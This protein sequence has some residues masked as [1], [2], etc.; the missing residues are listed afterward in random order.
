MRT[1]PEPSPEI[2]HVPL[3]H[4]AS[5]LPLAIPDGASAWRVRRL[6]GGRPRLYLDGNK[7]PLQLALGYTAADVEEILPPGSYR[8]DLVDRGGAPLDLVVPI[9]IAAYRNSAANDQ[10][11]EP[12]PVAPAV[13]PAAMS[14]VRL[15]LEANVRA[16]QMAFQHNE[17]TL[18]ASLR[19]AETLRDGVR[20]LAEA[21]GDWI[22]SLTTARGFSLRNVALPPAPASREV[23]END[24]D[25]DDDDD[26]DE[27]DDE[28]DVG[29]GDTWAPLTPLI[30]MAGPLVT[31]LVSD[32]LNRRNAAPTTASKKK[33][34]LAS[35]F[36]WRKAAPDPHQDP[37]PEAP[38]LSLVELMAAMPP[39][40][41]GRLMQVRA[42]LTANEQDRLKTLFQSFDPADLPMITAEFS[43]RTV[44]ELLAFLRARIADAVEG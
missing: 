4:D 2:T 40:V 1:Q 22:K 13:L 18:A 38:K 3:A 14:D 16:M 26:D 27:D 34:D 15:V 9:T 37:P 33:L 11:D 23:V 12:E 43:S 7:Q 39:D 25:D 30:A 44:D 8:L 6:T 32:W 42:Q 24:D 35:V 28:S 20:C 36:D 19:M 5:G 10:E 31:T 17:R 29:A 41:L 21:Q